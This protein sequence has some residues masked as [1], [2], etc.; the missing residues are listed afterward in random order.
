[1][2]LR[3][4]F[5]YEPGLDDVLRPYLWLDL[6]Y[7]SGPTIRV[8]GL[9]DTGADVTVLDTELASALGIADQELRRDRF[10]GSSGFVDA[11][12]TTSPLLATLPG[13]TQAALLT[14][15]FIDGAQTL[16]GR[17]L[18][19]TYGIALDERAKQFSLF[20]IES[21]DSVGA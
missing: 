21:D 11:R 3:A 18:L 17:D 13:E 10:L 5:V 7:G 15:V 12:R 19:N 16:W 20:E 1:M 9:I 14:P 4:K 2:S 6:R 8:R